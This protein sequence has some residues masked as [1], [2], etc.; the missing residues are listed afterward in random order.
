VAAIFTSQMH[1]QNNRLGLAPGQELMLARQLANAAASL[2]AQ[3]E[4]Q[5]SRQTSGQAA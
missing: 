4:Q 1:M 5:D 2:A 3:G